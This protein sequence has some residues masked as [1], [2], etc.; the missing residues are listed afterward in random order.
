[1]LIYPSSFILR[2]P[3][4]SIAINKKVKFDGARCPFSTF[5]RLQG[6]DHCACAQKWCHFSFFS[7][8]FQTKKI[9]ALR[10]KMIKIASRGVL[11]VSVIVLMVCWSFLDSF[12]SPLIFSGNI[13]TKLGLI[14]FWHSSAGEALLASALLTPIT[15]S[16]TSISAVTR[17]LLLLQNLV[18]PSL[19]MGIQKESLRWQRHLPNYVTV[20]PDFGSWVS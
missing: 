9:Q 10:P 13:E 2:K 6:D 12:L 7:K 8:I 1:M 16:I 17:Y 11:R 20:K 14:N 5:L 3:F 18:R 15:H 19:A 4:L